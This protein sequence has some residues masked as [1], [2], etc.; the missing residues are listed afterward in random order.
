VYQFGIQRQDQFGMV[1]WFFLGKLMV[2]LTPAKIRALRLALGL[3]VNEFAAI[4]GVTQ[5]AIQRWEAGLRY[6]RYHHLVHLD[7]LLAEA[8]EK[9][10]LVLAD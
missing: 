2:M 6:P 7:K 5:P 10:G 4:M 8:K 3:S 1:F 9:H